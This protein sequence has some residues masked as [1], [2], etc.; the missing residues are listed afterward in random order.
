MFMQQLSLFWLHVDR[1]PKEGDERLCGSLKPFNGVNK[2]EQEQGRVREGESIGTGGRQMSRE[3]RG[4]RIHVLL[5]F[6]FRG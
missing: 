2:T 6:N 5:P 4:T 1:I 3:S